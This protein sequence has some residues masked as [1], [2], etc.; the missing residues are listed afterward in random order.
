MNGADV[1]AMIDAKGSWGGE[2][3]LP[4]ELITVYSAADQVTAK[5]G[6]R[7][8]GSGKATYDYHRPFA[9]PPLSGVLNGTLFDVRWGS[10]P[11]TSGNPAFAAI[12]TQAGSGVKNIGLT[13]PQ[14][15]SAAAPQEWGSSIQVYD[16]Q[17]NAY[18][19]SIKSIYNYLG[20]W[21]VDCRA[22]T[23]SV[24]LSNLIVEDVQGCPINGFIMDSMSDWGSIRNC[25]FNIG[26]MKDGLKTG[27]MAWVA[28]NGVAF[29]LDG[30]DWAV[31]DRPQAFG[32]GHGCLIRGGVNYQGR[33][34]YI[35]NIP[36][37]DACYRG[38]EVIGPTDCAVKVLNGEFVQYNFTVSPNPDGTMPLSAK[39]AAFVAI[40]TNIKKVLFQGNEIFGP[41]RYAAYCQGVGDAKILNNF[42]EASQ[43]S[44]GAAWGAFN[45]GNANVSNN[46]ATG[47]PIGV[48]GVYTNGT[49]HVVSQ[50]NQ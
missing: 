36:Q 28:A 32:Y 1:Q 47:F 40:G 44:D 33:G 8:L 29:Q 34:P 31:L 41:A 2:V 39:G 10:G 24:G 21:A 19:I 5:S 14:D 7:L 35:L 23:G 27:L 26:F 22:S 17:R 43:G 46:T 18:G 12:R 20:Y 3:V 38:V 6:V 48:A 42:A 49:Q 15:I 37:F 25:N 11:G 16:P 30:N 9:T 50:G 4:A 13:Y 45:G